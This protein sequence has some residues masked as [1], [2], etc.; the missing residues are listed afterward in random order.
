MSVPTIQITEP[1][2]GESFSTNVKNQKLIGV[3]S[4]DA[5]EVY[6]NGSTTGVVYTPGGV[7][8]SVNVVLVTG[9]NIF[10]VK[11]KN[12]D[13]WSTPQVI[14]VT[15]TAIGDINL[16]ISEVEGVAIKRFSRALEVFWRENT[17]P[18]VIGYNVY[19]SQ[20]AAG[21]VGGY[22]KLNSS[23]IT[24]V[25]HTEEVTELISETEQL[26]GNI[27]TT[28]TKEKVT[29]N[30]IYKIRM[31]NLP[32]GSPIIGTIYFVVTAVGFDTVLK[33]EL[34]SNYSLEVYGAV[35]GYTELIKD[36]EKKTDFDLQLSIMQ[37]ILKSHENIDIKPGTVIRDMVN[38]VSEEMRKTYVI[39]SFYFNSLSLA[40]LK[41]FDDA[42]G[43]GVSDTFVESTLKTEL[44]DALGRTQAETQSMIDGA[45]DRLA[46]NCGIV[47]FIGSKARGEVTFYFFAV[48]DTDI[49][50]GQGARVATNADPERGI[51][52]VEYETLKGI[53]ISKDSILGFYNRDKKRY[54]VTLP[55]QAIAVGSIGN[56]PAGV[57][58]VSGSGV[59]IGIRAENETE[60]EL[61]AD[62]ETNYD[63]SER[64]F[65]KM[66][67]IDTGMLNGYVETALGVSGVRKVKVVA[68]GNLYMFRD[69]D[70]LR[71]EH[72]GGKVDVYIYG[73][74][75]V[76]IEKKFA[77][78]YQTQ[79]DENVIIDNVP[80]LRFRV[81]NP[82]VSLSQPIFEVLQVYNVTRHAAYSLNNLVIESGVFIK[83]DPT[84][85]VNILIGLDSL[86]IVRATYR[87]RKNLIIV[88]AGPVRDIV[89]IAGNLSGD[90]RNNYNWRIVDE[91][92]LKGGSIQ[93]QQMIEIFFEGG[94][95][96]TSYETI[97]DEPVT[98][99]G[100][101]DSPL[102]NYG[103]ITGTVVVQNQT[104]T[105]TYTEGI[106][107][108]LTYGDNFTST[109]IKRIPT[110]SIT[111]GQ[112]VLVSYQSGE[113]I[114]LKY[115]LN[116]LVETVQKR[117][118]D[119]KHLTADAIVKEIDETPVEIRMRVKTAEG[120]PE[121]SVKKDILTKVTDEFNRRR[122]GEGVYQSDVVGKVE[123]VSG[124]RYV[125]LPL[126]KMVREN[127]DIIVREGIAP[128]WELISTFGIKVWR[129]T[130]PVLK[131][132][133]L[134]G[135]G[136]VESIG[137][138]SGKKYYP[139][140]VINENE[141]VFIAI[142]NESDINLAEFQSF[143]R[144][145]GKIE[146]S[147]ALDPN[148]LKYYVDYRV[149]G[150]TGANDI[151]VGD[152][153]FVHLQLLESI[154]F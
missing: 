86:D 144:A 4:A 63:L 73:E 146:I 44:M 42:N 131:F 20:E 5:L 127:G 16:I 1:H 38:P 61:G 7:A 82:D 106:D 107:Y 9:M 135:G 21:G 103:V 94:L 84:D 92:V 133:T 29:T 147:Y 93:E 123:I 40:G 62:L 89:S 121:T 15:L 67:G 55:I 149:F 54:E 118:D 46:S 132:P 71:K 50:I 113:N 85:P 77:F 52:S 70:T 69:Y 59:P 66:V 33:E 27:M 12:L 152:F 11:A 142:E 30:K 28:T 56:Q 34:E 125:E 17:D 141:A 43:D 76:Q 99:T 53:T 25:D 35:F 143:I 65:R 57:I 116:G 47:R 31:E 81:T 74:N 98:L 90:L 10:E 3:V 126:L 150:Q 75:L 2:G 18:G 58:V 100:E 72:I 115:I 87:F 51:A 41:A 8:W 97:T 136:L 154:I 6:V 26:D 122:I 138:G 124:V 134:D 88:L 111:D 151:E 23:L 109:L 129:T 95:P 101:L 120:Y 119:F 32:D 45:F 153:E 60:V 37:Q 39:L 117:V 140:K 13:G 139:I 24:V 102:V 83:L 22:I 80:G 145:D 19:Y 114:T 91:R 148:S 79:Q 96:V 78:L 137:T 108:I 130:M 14:I 110:G 128:I 105:L 104:K 49:V 48:P 36:I 68:A 64:I 112:K